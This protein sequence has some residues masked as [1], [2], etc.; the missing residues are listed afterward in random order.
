M[1]ELHL[2]KADRKQSAGSFQYLILGSKAQA[3]DFAYCINNNNNKNR[4][5]SLFINLYTYS[6]LPVVDI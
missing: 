4:Y 1:Y 6:Y 5:H 2:Y 3:K